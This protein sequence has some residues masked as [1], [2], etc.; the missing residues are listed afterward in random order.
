[1]IVASIFALIGALFFFKTTPFKPL[2]DLMDTTK[3][4]A[5]GEG[6]LTKR[7][8][9]KN[10]DKIG[11][12]TGYINKFIEKIQI[13]VIGVG[14]TAS[15]TK[16]ISEKTLTNANE[17]SKSIHLKTKIVQESKLVSKVEKEI[18]LSEN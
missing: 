5:E 10:D 6:D 3:D 11:S 13:T 18:N 7:L 14:K 16:V 9:A 15:E 8:K 12:V 4:L 2:Q 1:M 17:I